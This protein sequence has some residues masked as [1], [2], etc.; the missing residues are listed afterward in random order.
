VD[1]KVVAIVGLVL[2]SIFSMIVLKGDSV[3]IV[4]VCVG[5]IGGAAVGKK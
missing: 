4:G 3:N 1:D 5:A 2:I